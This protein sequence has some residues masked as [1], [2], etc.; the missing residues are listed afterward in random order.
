VGE[1]VIDIVAGGICS[2]AVMMGWAVRGRSSRVFAPSVY[3]GSRKRKAIALTFDDGPS[4]ST[5]RILEELARHQ[6]PATFFQCGANVRRLPEAAREVAAAGHE[7]GN[8]SDTHPIFCFKSRAFM[9]G[10]LARAQESIAEATSFTPR[11]LRVPYGVRWPGLDQAQRG[12]NLMGVMW[13][14]IGLDWKL[15][16][17]RVAVRV[18]G[19]V[20]NGGIIC[21]HDGREMREK[22]DISS[23]IEA[24][25]ILVPEL[26][27]RGYAF[28]TVGSLL[29]S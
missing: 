22:P 15:S 25:R 23:T 1:Y 20:R 16:G 19:G 26:L 24:V 14:V 3:R 2:G 11:H 10:E 12:L 7:I 17:R 6:V 21:L 28:E 8:H 4:E 29:K 27:E 5:V 13:T 9:H 18:M